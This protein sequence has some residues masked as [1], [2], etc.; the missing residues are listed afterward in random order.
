MNLQNS[1]RQPVFLH[2]SL[3]KFA[4]GLAILCLF[5]SS[6]AF[7]ADSE[8]QPLSD[9]QQSIEQFVLRSLPKNFRID[10]QVGKLDPRLRLGRCEQPLE[11][12]YPVSARKMGPTTI[13]VR[14]LSS[15]PWQ[16]YVPVQIRVFGPAVVSKH[17]LLRGSVIEA[18]DLTIS[19]RELSN[20]LNGYYASIEEVA[21]M[22][23]RFNLAGGTIIGPRSLKPQFLVKRGDIITILAETN[24]L[25]IR[26]K[27][28][29]LMDGFKGQSIRIKNTR[30]DR[31]LQGEV[32]ASRTVKIDL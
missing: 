9:I 13:G 7:G 25:Q 29:A 31:E 2:R 5:H 21:G 19:T 17:A 10:T 22:E 16:I 14:C 26:V 8:I 4:H 15:S 30:S 20:A 6:N 3:G 27:G 32:V 24:G 18:R 11:S 1:Y 12:F 23:L 28:T